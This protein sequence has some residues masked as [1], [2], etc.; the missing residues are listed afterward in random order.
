MV[1]DD[2]RDVCIAE[3][4]AGRVEHGDGPGAGYVT[5][6]ADVRADIDPDEGGIHV[7]AEVGPIVRDASR[8]ARRRRRDRV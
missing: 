3:R 5:L 6:H 7:V 4:L 8:V 2:E 1:Q